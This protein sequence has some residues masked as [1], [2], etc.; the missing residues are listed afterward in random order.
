MFKAATSSRNSTMK[1]EREIPPDFLI[2]SVNFKRCCI[3]GNYINFVKLPINSLGLLVNLAF[4]YIPVLGS[5]A[6]HSA[7]PASTSMHDVG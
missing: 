5:A 4:C 3:Q 1:R 7:L 2:K 6:A